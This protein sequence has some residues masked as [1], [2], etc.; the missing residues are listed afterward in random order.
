MGLAEKIAIGPVGPEFGLTTSAA[1]TTKKRARV[2]FE[3]DV[4]GSSFLCA[5]MF[6]SSLV[7]LSLETFVLSRLHFHLHPIVIA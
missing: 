7:I 2:H 1:S 6:E 3:H 5:C 4:S